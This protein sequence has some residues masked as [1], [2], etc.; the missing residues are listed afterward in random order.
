MTFTKNSV[1]V[2]TWVSLVVSGAFTKEQVPKLFNLR[3]VVNEVVDGLV[4]G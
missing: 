3:T 4:E 2:K 1:L